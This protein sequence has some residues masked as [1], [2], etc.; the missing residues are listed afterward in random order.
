V[1]LGDESAPWERY[2]IGCLI[3]AVG[4]TAKEVFS[5]NDGRNAAG[6]INEA[7]KLALVFGGVEKYGE[8]GL[9]LA[10]DDLNRNMFAYRTRQDDAFVGFIF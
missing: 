4:S 2:A 6:Y 7:P 10:N 3:V 8:T 9:Y 5:Q 1:K